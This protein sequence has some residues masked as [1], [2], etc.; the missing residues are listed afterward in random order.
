MIEQL[1]T[2]DVASLNGQET[3]RLFDRAQSTGIIDR[4]AECFWYKIQLRVAEKASN[5]VKTIKIAVKS[6]N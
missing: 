1:S 5:A 4:F 2:I 3:Q 6:D